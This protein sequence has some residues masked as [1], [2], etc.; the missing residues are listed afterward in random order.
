MF[1]E[2]MTYLLNID[3]LPHSFTKTRHVLS[4]KELRFFGHY[5]TI[6]KYSKDESVQIETRKKNVYKI[7]H[8]VFI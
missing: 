2:N 1:I 6:V 7:M 8:M 3:D 5:V 4:Y